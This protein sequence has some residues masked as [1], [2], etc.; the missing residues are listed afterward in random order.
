M[1]ESP[2]NVEVVRSLLLPFGGVN[3]AK[4]DWSAEPIREL[5]EAACAAD[6]ELRTLESGVGTGVGD[7][8]RGIDGL[9]DYLLEWMEPFG[10]YQ[11]DWLDYV[12]HGDFVLVP[13]TQWGIGGASGVR[14]ELD[15][16]YAC[17]LKNGRITRVLQHDTLEDARS[18]VEADG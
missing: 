12:E 4:I 8:Y 1:S 5:L 17:E 2:E 3:V 16:T 14:V 11:I 18:A 10:E 15:V 6:V 9:V 7:V 13:S